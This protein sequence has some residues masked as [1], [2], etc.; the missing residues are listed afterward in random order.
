VR[1]IGCLATV[2]ALAAGLTSCTS[3]DDA[4]PGDRGWAPAPREV[5]GLTVL[6]ESDADGFR[7]HT[8]SGGKGFLPGVNLGSTVPL[9]QP[10][11][12]GKIS[13]EQYATW[14]E[15][16]GA[17]GVRVVRI[18]TLPPPAFYDEL[19]SYN[20]DHPT[21]PLYLFQG[22]Y[23]PD[24]G[25]VEEGRSLYDP[26]IDVS[27]SR[28]LKDISDAVHGDLVR[29]AAPGRAGGKYTTDVSPWLAGWIIGVEWDPAGVERTDRLDADAPYKPGRYFVAG[30]GATATERWIATHMDELAGWEAARGTSAPLAMA[31][32]PTA[33]PLHH[34]EEPRE[35]ED[36]VSIDATHVLPTDAW[37]GGTFASFHAY[38][39]YPDFQR[40]EPGIQDEQWNGRGDPY[41]G[42]VARLRDHYA[43]T[44]PLMVTE[45]GVPSS[46]GSAHDG[47]LGRDQGGHSEQEAMAMVADMTRMLEAKGVAGAFVFI[48]EDEWFKRTWN[49]MEHQDPDR[50]QLWH[51]PL[52]NEQWFGLVATD[53]DPLVDAAVEAAPTSGPFEY[54]YVWADASWVHL[55]ITTRDEVPATLRVEADVV[56]GR[57]RA[58]Y[59]VLVDTAARTARL[60]V[61]SAL[62]PIRLDTPERPY[63]PGQQT[64]WHLYSLIIRGGLTL[65]G[66]AYPAEFQDVGVLRE[67]T[68]DPA[69]PAYDSRSTWQ[70]DD[71]RRTLRLRLPW[72]MLGMAD[73]SSRLALGE[74]TPAE[75]VTIDGIGLTFDADGAR[76]SLTFAWPAWNHT[77]WTTRPKAG[78]EVVE[79]AFRDL[80][81]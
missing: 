25:Y 54:L 45:F 57:E 46:L 29:D 62:D 80:A 13:R 32:W 28:E 78:I 24:E 51:D 20:R 75:R 34:P 37:P 59:R 47:P 2:L 19:A 70:V 39:Y 42:Y 79:Q 74:G 71:E 18:Y 9:L 30:Q 49:T 10:G 73:P 81:P 58:D 65:D 11:E 52:T 22:A 43:G 27:F 61:R 68:W 53:P 16:M 7:L 23:L 14:M 48:W 17:S 21:A 50:R 6:A 72:S 5:A 60:E 63:R 56:P 41:A 38:P 44:M 33:D 4:P 55:E 40:Y 1:G 26:E 66:R 15:D 36:L 3:T 64:P 76:E 8:A 67:G 69:S 12:I 31:N 35:S 77:T